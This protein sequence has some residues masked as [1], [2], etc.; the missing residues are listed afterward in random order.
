MPILNPGDF[1]LDPKIVDGTD[2]AGRLNRL[3]Q[4]T[5]STNTNTTRP[6]YI[7]AGGLWV[8]D[9]G[10]GAKDRY[11]LMMFD[12]TNDVL[13]G[14]GRFDQGTRLIFQQT[15]APTGWTKVTSIDNHALRVVS[16]T[17]GSGGSVDFTVAFG[18]GSGMT[19]GHVLTEAEMPHHGHGVG[20]PG[21]SHGVNDPG[22]AHN[23]SFGGFNGYPKAAGNEL[24]LTKDHVSL[25][26]LSEGSGTGISIHGSGSNI[27]IHGNGGN[28]PHSHTIQSNDVKYV[29][30]II[31]AKD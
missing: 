23:S 21:H 27:S 17:A 15:A 20:D 11:E 6:P 28:Q 14:G 18:A 9:N 5:S 26:K 10:Y 2:L 8:K 25:G 30:V 3:E 4:A 13:A 7:L 16:G 12:G 29:D 1:P 22:H 24:S 31:C 19:G